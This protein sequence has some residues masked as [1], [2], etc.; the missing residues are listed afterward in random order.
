M[1]P[2][3]NCL[4]IFK[5]I[6]DEIRREK[7]LMKRRNFFKKI[8]QSTLLLPTASLVAASFSSRPIL[9]ANDRVFVG[10]IGCGGRGTFVTRHMRQVPNVTINAVCDVYEKNRNSAKSVFEVPSEPHKDFRQLLE[11]KD[12]DAVIIGTPDHWHAIVTVLAC[13]AGKDVYVEKPLAHNIKEG[14][15][16]VKAARQHNRVVQTGTQQRSAPHFEEIRRIIQ[17]GELGKVHFIR[18]WNY[19]N[20]Y[21]RGIGRQNDAD[22]PLGLDWDFYLGPAPKVPFNKNR[23]LGTFRWFWDYSGGVI[24]DFGTHRFDSM[25]QVMGVDAPR[26]ISASGSRFALDDGGE[27]PDI[28][29]VTY[30]YPNFVLSYEA[31]VL[32]AHGVGGRTP[33]RKYYGASSDDDRPNGL[34]FYG[35]KGA[36]FADRIGFEIYPDRKPYDMPDEPSSGSKSSEQL[37]LQNREMSAQ[38]ATAQ[39]VANFIGCVRSRQKSAADVA[40]GHRSTIVPHLGNIAYKTGMK[41]TWDGTKEE[42]VNNTEASKLLSRQARKPWDILG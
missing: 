18:I 13:A 26:T 7:L 9:G 31:C 33:G 30:T 12:V 29:Q 16:M 8:S 3:G 40:I 5:S 28:L 2:V 37:S 34:A 25:H 21:P 41:I 10:L 24:T 19:R 39:H 27:I 35:T 17:N 38:D 11:R 14:Q 23:F 15:A 36:L 42:I 4:R 20:M 32:N 1:N 6:H 22:V